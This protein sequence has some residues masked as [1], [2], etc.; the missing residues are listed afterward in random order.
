[1]GTLVHNRLHSY[2]V[3]SYRSAWKKFIKWCNGQEE[4]RLGWLAASFIIHGCIFVPMTIIC[5]AGSG[6]SFGF[7]ALALGAMILAVTVN[8]ADL[9]TKITLPVFF[10]SLVLDILIIIT[11]LF[12]GLN[13]HRLFIR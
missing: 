10:F 4:N 12:H 9:P 8:L 11:R 2:P 5:I 7:V 6:N 13:M 1:M 3:S